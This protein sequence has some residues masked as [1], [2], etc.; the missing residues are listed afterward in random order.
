MKKIIGI[1]GMSCNH[2]VKSVTKSL[3]GVIGV[4]VIS[5]S[6]ENKNAKVEVN[7]NVSDQMLIEAVNDA[8]YDVTQ[9]I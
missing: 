8:G 3:N 1:E 2:C 7:E 6:L 9:I 5:V 4:N